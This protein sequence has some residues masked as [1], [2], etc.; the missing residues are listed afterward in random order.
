MCGKGGIFVF[1]RV[2]CVST[3]ASGPICNVFMSVRSVIERERGRHAERETELYSIT[4]KVS[5]SWRRLFIIVSGSV[6]CSGNHENITHS[7]RD[8]IAKDSLYVDP[9]SVHVCVVVFA[10]VFYFVFY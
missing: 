3:H 2:D 1:V 5:D 9:L 6:V 8:Q 7:S 4:V 10:C